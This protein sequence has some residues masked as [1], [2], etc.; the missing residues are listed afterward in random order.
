MKRN[1]RPSFVFPLAGILTMSVVAIGI[2][3]ATD[4]SFAT[5]PVSP[6]V[7]SGQYADASAPPAETK[8]APDATLSL[9]GGQVAVGVGYTWGSGTLDFDGTKHPFKISGISVANVGASTLNASGKVYDLK[10]IQDF[11]GTYASVAAGV[12]VGGGGSVAYLRNQNGVVIMLTST[13]EGLDFQLS[14]NG[15]KITLE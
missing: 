2:Y 9:S 10:R 15:T 13:Q 5:E 11:A 12:T 6:A 4:L 8:G 14:G 7:G 1:P 3:A